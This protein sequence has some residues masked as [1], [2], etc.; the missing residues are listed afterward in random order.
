MTMKKINTKHHAWCWRCLYRAELS[1]N[2][3]ECPVIKW[4]D[5]NGAN[6]FWIEDPSIAGETICTAFAQGLGASFGDS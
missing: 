1:L 6:L 5:E 4:Q 2:E 3:E